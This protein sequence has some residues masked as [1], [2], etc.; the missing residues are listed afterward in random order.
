VRRLLWV[1][2]GIVIVFP[3]GLAYAVRTSVTQNWSTIFVSVT[4]QAI[5]FLVLGVTV[6][7]VLHALLPASFLSRTFSARPRYAIPAAGVGGMLLPGCECSSVPVAGRLIDKGITPAA[8]LTFLLA[9]PAINPVVLVSTV[10]AFP[11]RPEVALARL[12]AALSAA[13]V[14]GA[15]WSWRRGA[16]G[17]DVRLSSEDHGSHVHDIVSTASADFVQ[18]GGFLVMGAAL[19][20]S[21]QTFVP[22]T[23]LDSLGGSSASAVLSLGVLAVVLSICSEADAFV[24]AGLPQFPM[25]ARLAFMVVGPMVDLKLIGLQAGTFG[26]RFAL[27]FA[28][29]TFAVALAMSG[30]VG[31]ALL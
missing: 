20:A 9:A 23:L 24:A 17:L 19:V 21:L 3:G 2:A 5:P 15:L 26:P 25:T 18:A 28:P 22:Q 4:L 13:V 10:V 8:G 12:L 30:V 11:G 1:A 29:V 7:A 14:V 16:D 31:S 6:G 27:W